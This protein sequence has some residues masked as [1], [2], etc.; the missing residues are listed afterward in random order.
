MDG[1]DLVFTID[2]AKTKY[3]FP[4][5]SK[6]ISKTMSLIQECAKKGQ[7]I[8]RGLMV[9][10]FSSCSSLLS[11]IQSQFGKLEVIAFPNPS[12]AI[13]RGATFFDRF[14]LKKLVK[15][16]IGLEVSKRLSELNQMQL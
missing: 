14:D 4:T 2:F 3:L 1:D 5:K 16:G 6:L 10:G 13:V 7:V 15:H 12:L 11:D 9:G 8:D